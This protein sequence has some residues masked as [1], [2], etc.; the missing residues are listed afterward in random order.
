MKIFRKAI[1]VIY[2]IFSIILCHAN[3][4]GITVTNNI[5]KPTNPIKCKDNRRFDELNKTEFLPD[6]FHF[7]NGK[8]AT[9]GDWNCRRYEIASQLEAFSLGIKEPAPDKTLAKLE[10]NLL[11][12]QIE[13]Q[14]KLTDFTAEITWPTKGKAPYPAVIGIGG[15]WINNDQLLEQGIA[16]IKFPNNEIAEQLNQT[17]RGKGKFY[18]L[19]GKDHSAGA[20]MAWAWGVSRLIY[21][22]DIKR[23]IPWSTPLLN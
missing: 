12:I 8:A 13:H 4:M 21:K 16:L 17:S 5:S 23:W 22:T 11:K 9:K 15:S 18:E 10:G 7:S 14:G 2:M 20:L 1:L 3:D 6:P 19:Y